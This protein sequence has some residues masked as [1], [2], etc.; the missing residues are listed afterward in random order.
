[1]VTSLYLALLIV[2]SF[3]YSI[4]SVRGGTSGGN[5]YYGGKIKKVTYCTCWYDFG[6]MLEIED[7]SNFNQTLK[8]FYNPYISKLRAFYNIW[9]AGPQVIGGYLPTYQACEM[10]KSYYCNT[11]DTTSGV[12][13]SIKGIGTTS[14]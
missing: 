6:V 4:Q 7:K 14:S 1:M 9:T 11:E 2:G 8:V 5:F 13:D 12:I 10:T 3:S